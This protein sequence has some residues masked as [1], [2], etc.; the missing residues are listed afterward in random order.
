MTITPEDLQAAVQAERE[1]CAALAAKI[2]NEY[3]DETQP[4]DGLSGTMAAVNLHRFWCAL[5][6]Y[7]VECAILDPR[8]TT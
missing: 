6:A 7:H 5:G 4:R 1:R 8:E 3:L 2:F